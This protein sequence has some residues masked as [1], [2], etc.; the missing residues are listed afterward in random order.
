MRNACFRSTATKVLPTLAVAA[1]FIMT[2]VLSVAGE[3]PKFHWVDDADNGTA[4]LSLG[5]QP[6]LRYMYAYDTTN[7]QRTHETFKVYHHVFGPGNGKIITKGPGGKY[8][9]HRGLFVGWNKT[10]FE[11]QTLDFWHCRK[12]E[13]LRHIKFVEKTGDEK[14]GSMT[15]EI[16]WIDREGKPVIVETRSVTVTKQS[17]TGGWQIDWRTK[18]ASK[19]GTVTLDGDRQHAGFQFR[20]AQ[21]IAEANSARY[22]RPAGFPEQPAAYQVNDRSDPDKHVDLNWLAMTFPLHGQDYTIEYFES[23]SVPK[24]SRYSE[25]P[26]G[27]FGAFFQTQITEEKPLEIRYRVNVSAAKPQSRRLIQ[28]RFDAFIKDLQGN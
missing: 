19:R 24:P 4:D 7:E 8:T 1:S 17:E 12:G 14:S 6:V 28:N 18:L 15:A 26:Y 20:A 2:A 5:D 10:S 13:H 21:P 23:P 27:R 25:R 3:Q 16:R 11:G 22:V 9:H